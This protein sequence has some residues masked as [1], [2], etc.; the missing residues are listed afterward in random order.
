M[1]KVHCI[2]PLKP[3]AHWQ[4]NIKK[5]GHG[6]TELVQVSRLSSAPTCI[7]FASAWQ[8]YPIRRRHWGKEKIT[9]CRL[10]ARRWWTFWGQSRT[11]REP[12]STRTSQLQCLTQ[13]PALSLFPVSSDQYQAIR[14]LPVSLESWKQCWNFTP[15]A[16]TLYHQ[17]MCSRALLNSTQFRTMPPCD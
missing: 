2:G 5:T 10:C 14:Y 4:A 9:H 17:A 16:E 13:Q 8:Q 1:E 15:I 11:S 12:W 3:T 6:A 7:N